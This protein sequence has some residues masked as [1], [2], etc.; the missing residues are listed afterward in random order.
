[1]QESAQESAAESAPAEGDDLDSA[2]ASKAVAEPKTN[3]EAEFD[4]EAEST[5]SERAADSGAPARRARRQAGIVP[6]G[7]AS[8]GSGVQGSGVQESG[9]QGIA[10]V[11]GGL[12]EGYQEEFS[13]RLATFKQSRLRLEQAL[14]DQRETYIRY[15]NKEQQSAAYREKFEQQRSQVR[16]LMDQTYLDALDVIR[17]GLDQEAAT[18]VATMVQ[19]RFG[20]DIYDAPT[21]EGAAR[22]IDGGSKMTYLF[23]A[24]ARSAIVE[25][26]FDMAKRLYEAIDDD[27]MEEIDET[28][29]FFLDD[30]KESIEWEKTI[31]EKEAEEDRL[32]RVSLKTTQGDVVLE[33]F[34]DHSPSTVS[35]F[36][37]LVENGF[38][39]G[40][41]FY[42]VID[43][44]FALTGD[45]SG[46]GSGNSGKF[47]VDEHDPENGRRGL[48]GTLVMAKLPMGDSGKFIPNSASSQFA[49]L[50]LPVVS[51]SK[52]QTIFGRVIEGMDVVSRLR[53]VD[54][55][56]K[57][58]KGE[59]VLPPDRIIEAKVIRRPETLPEPNYVDMSGR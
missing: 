3:E 34:L 40:L 17:M 26:Q 45:P 20:L 33:L 57:K 18:Y 1:M 37:G 46:V 15:L 35:H 8:Q 39:D 53:R 4:G 36:I 58:G 47:L 30:Y 24:A 25:G 21:M 23:Q 38:Y 7:G 22:L 55:N 10:G 12:P 32:P 9:V 54:P 44:L 51:I 29:Q 52:E 13:K 50:Y 59:V 16:K 27:Q 19:H 41:D 28:M 56:K 42:Q 11:A 43:H 49:I 48:R 6:Q 14:G 5:T 31:R 2:G